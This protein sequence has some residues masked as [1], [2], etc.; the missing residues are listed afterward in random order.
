MRCAVLAEEVRAFVSKHTHTHTHKSPLRSL[1]T[2]DDDAISLPSWV[3]CHAHHN[4]LINWLSGNWAPA[5]KRERNP[6]RNAA[7][8][9]QSRCTVGKASVQYVR[10]LGRPDFAGLTE[11]T[12]CS[13]WFNSLKPKLV[14]KLWAMETAPGSHRILVKKPPPIQCIG[15]WP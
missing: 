6:Q 9:A 10:T 4:S 8:P 5:I 12:P 15:L 7:I 3:C 2:V 11:L 14:P 13:S 1:V